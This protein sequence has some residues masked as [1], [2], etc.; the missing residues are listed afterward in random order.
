MEDGTHINELY[1]GDFYIVTHSKE[2]FDK[3]ISKGW[4]RESD[5]DKTYKSVN[6][7]PEAHQKAWRQADKDLILKTLRLNQVIEAELSPD[8]DEPAQ[9]A[10]LARVMEAQRKLKALAPRRAE[11]DAARDVFFPKPA[12]AVT[13][14]SVRKAS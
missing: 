8:A 9:I 7:T 14:K 10:H 12:V 5:P 1:Q 3:F 2:E 13:D 6:D 11:V 4:V